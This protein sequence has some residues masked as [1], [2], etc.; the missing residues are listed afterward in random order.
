MNVSPAGT[1]AP[2]ITASADLLSPIEIRGVKLRSRIVMSPMCQF[3]A[4]DGV[5][6]DWHLVHLAARAVGGA[7]LVFTEA[8]AVT[9]QGRITPGDLGI[10]D[11]AH[12]EPLRKIVQNVVARGAVPGIQFGHAGR[13]ASRHVPWE[14]SQPLTPEEGSWPIVGPSPIPFE[15]DKAQTP[16]ELTHEGIDAVVTAFEAATC[17]AI[18]IGFQ[19]IEIHAAHGYLMHE[20]LSP[21]SNHRQDEYGGSLEN[22]MRLLLRVVERMRTVMPDRMPLSVRISATDW[23]AGEP[24]WDLDQSVVLARR[25]KAAGVDIV[26]ASSGA[27][28]L[29]Q[30][31]AIGPE[32]QVPF[33]RRIRAEAHIM[34]GA[35]GLITQ[36]RQAN[37]I[38]VRG[39]ADLVFIGRAFLRNPYWGLVAQEE[40]TGDAP[41]PD[42]YGYH[43]VRR[44]PK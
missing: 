9:P 10:W 4:V 2:S 28:S 11:D 41:W 7:A 43:A 1:Q 26:D 6:N 40:L 44:K 8:A 24:S 35:V 13:K 42:Q 20:F 29:R 33:A 5:A 31:I 27:L 32:Y 38:I 22:R 19:V 14:S 15:E 18:A 12:T 23:I 25:L 21:V 36:P 39:D 3:C 17:R 34:T 30:K 16:I 37:E